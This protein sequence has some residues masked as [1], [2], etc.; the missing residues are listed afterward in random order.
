MRSG[1]SDAV[2]YYEPKSIFNDDYVVLDQTKVPQNTIESIESK[3]IKV[4]RK[5]KKQFGGDKKQL[6]EKIKEEITA[7]SNGNVSVDQL[8]EFVVNLCAQDMIDKKLSK[9]DVEGF[10]SAFCY[11]AYGATNINSISEMVFTK[12]DQITEKLAERKWANPPP[13]DCNKDFQ[14]DAIDEKDSHNPRIRQLLNQIEDKV[15]C[16]GKVKMY[17]IFRKFDRD[18]DGYVTYDDFEKCLEHI[19]VPASK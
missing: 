2:D 3:L 8:K 7:D 18:C 19:Q 13:S 15:F 12:D 10:L 16:D 5:L 11:N 1:L 17:Q 4:N 9:R 6:E 14:R